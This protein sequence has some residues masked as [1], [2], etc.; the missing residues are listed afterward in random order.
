MN[1]Y[2]PEMI[3]SFGVPVNNIAWWA[4]LTTAIFCICQGFTSIAWGAASDRFGRKPMI[5]LGLVNTM[6]MMLVWGFSTSLPMA[7]TAR[8]VQ[9]LGNGNV[10][11]LRTVVA[12][13]CPWKVSIEPAVLR[14]KLSTNAPVGT[15]ASRIQ[16]HAIRL[17]HWGCDWSGMCSKLEG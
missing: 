9:G 16:H 13:L 2:L 15:A 8:A 6:T 11:I 14:W 5:L 3:E 7:M 12:E 10:G 4:G 1:P 17:H